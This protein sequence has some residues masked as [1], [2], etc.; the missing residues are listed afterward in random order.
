MSINRS[1]TFTKSHENNTIIIHTVR[2]SFSVHVRTVYGRGYFLRTQQNKR[3]ERNRTAPYT[4]IISR[5]MDE[6]FSVPDAVPF[7]S[8]V[9]VVLLPWSFF[10]S[11]HRRTSVS[12]L[13][14]ATYAMLLT[15]FNS[16][17]RLLRMNESSRK[18]W[19]DIYDGGFVRSKVVVFGG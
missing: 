3:K 5:R 12:R 13:F 16:C 10:S 1:T 9:V 7:S 8:V 18:A 17:C 2:S 6:S 14:D 11:S 4:I 19:K 15:V